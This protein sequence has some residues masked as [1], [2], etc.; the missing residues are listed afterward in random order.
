MKSIPILLTAFFF[1]T[2]ARAQQS[3]RLVVHFDFNRSNI[4]AGARQQLDSLVNAN[5]DRFAFNSIQIAAHCDS[6]GNNHYNDELSVRRA[7][8]V[9]DYLIQSGIN[10]GV[11][12]KLEGH[13]KRQPLNQNS[14]AEERFLNRRVELIVQKVA[15]VGE[16]PASPEKT[17]TEVIRDTGTKVGQ[18]IVLRNLNFEGGR[19]IMLQR[20]MPILN[21]LLEAMQQNPNLKIEI[22]GHVCC[23]ATYL[24]GRDNDLGTFDLSWQRAKVVYQF[25]IDKNVSADRMSYKGFGASQKLFPEERDAYEQE[26]NRR[27][28][29]KIIRK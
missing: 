21:E 25:L 17:I 2:T 11:I 22:H 16:R 27:V 9:R 26:E 12:T 24:D 19:H 15:A 13:G 6:I 29:I 8:A 5:K 18:T 10:D 23:T 28:E 4:N 20:S 7:N 1:F 3:D 14:N